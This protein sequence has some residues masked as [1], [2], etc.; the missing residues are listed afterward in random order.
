MLGEAT[1]PIDLGM[2]IIYGKTPLTRE[3]EEALHPTLKKGVSFVVDVNADGQ[4]ILLV[5][6]SMRFTHPDAPENYMFWGL[7]ARKQVFGK[8]DAKL[9]ATQGEDAADITAIIT[10]KWDPRIRV[11]LDKQAKDQTAILRISTS[12]PDS[13]AIWRIERRVTVLGDAVHCMPPTGGQG[14]NSALYDA[15]LLG[16]AL[17]G[18]GENASDGW[19][20][21][22][23]KGYEDALRNN[24]GDV[25][26]LACIGISK[27]I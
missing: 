18:S 4:K 3:V 6:E 1:A 16:A 12:N 27:I 8:D 24:I 14:A 9:L 20:T 26:G 25:V 17:G 19:S 15:A 13:P 10:A 23:I 7:S 22:T 2:R 21:E 5:I 11:I